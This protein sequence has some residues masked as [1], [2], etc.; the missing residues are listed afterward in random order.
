MFQQIQKT[1]TTILI[2][3]FKKNINQQKT[4]C[5]HVDY[6]CPEC[7]Q[8]QC[9]LPLKLKGLDVR[10]MLRIGAISHFL[11]LSASPRRF[12]AGERLNG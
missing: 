2:T 11:L 8:T 6:H 1:V 3:V 7:L 10:Q 12:P 5:C 9:S 4:I